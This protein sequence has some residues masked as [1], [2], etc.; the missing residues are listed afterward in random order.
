MSVPGRVLPLMS[1]V[2]LAALA[3]A[4]GC[5]LQ[6][7]TDYRG[8]P[9]AR[10]SGTITSSVDDPPSTLRPLLS[11]SNVANPGGV[12]F[13]LEEAPVVVEF[14]AQFSFE[15]FRPP[16]DE[17]IND[18]TEGGAHP[19]EARVGVAH[20]AAWPAELD[21]S[22]DERP[23]IYGVAE[24]YLLVH[25]DRDVQPGTVSAEILGGEIEAGYHLMDVI[26]SGEPGCQDDAYDC[27]RL[28]PDDLDTEIVI[29]IDRFELL[30]FP[31]WT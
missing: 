6:A 30:D 5:E 8:E 12:S 24:N 13:A 11:W 23:A 18:Y 29:R 28:S 25:V 31:D 9:L 21:P 17:G 3:G 2:L 15:L 14:P 7:G 10:I 16:L 20:I 19:D 4:S 1:I 22:S 27:M 26:E